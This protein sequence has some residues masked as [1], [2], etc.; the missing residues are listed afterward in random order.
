MAGGGKGSSEKKSKTQ[1]TH[2]E[3]Q[4]KGAFGTGVRFKIR[5]SVGGE[6]MKHATIAGSKEESRKGTVGGIGVDGAM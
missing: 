6:R 3:P 5:P 1:L 4:E 2:T